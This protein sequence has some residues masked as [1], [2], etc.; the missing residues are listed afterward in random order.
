MNIAA[1]CS[2]G[3]GYLADHPVDRDF[4]SEG[5]EAHAHIAARI[6]GLPPPDCSDPGVPW[7]WLEEL[8]EE[9]GLC[10]EDGSVECATPPLE[11]GG[12]LTTG[13]TDWH[14]SDGRRLVVVDWK[15]GEGQRW[16]LPPMV[17]WYQGLLY[18]VQ[19]WKNEEEVLL[20]RPRLCDREVDELRLT[21]AL[22]EEVIYPGLEEIVLGVAD[23]PDTLHAGPWC[24]G[25]LC[26]ETCPARAEQVAPWLALPVALPGPLELAQALRWAQARGAVQAACEAA[27]AALRA[28][29]REGGVIEADGYRLCLVATSRESVSDVERVREVVGPE[30]VEVKV[31][32]S[33]TL[34][35]R[36]LKKRKYKPDE[37]AEVL[38]QLRAAGAIVEKETA[39]RLTWKQ[40]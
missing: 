23:A 14:H 16:I 17:R 6:S 15:W 25:C 35:E 32:S 33:K 9:Y 29:L 39:G 28:F 10:W 27:D 3:P 12:Y 31:T 22:I 24:E 38:N 20:L 11:I 37:R 7:D 2:G 34:I 18:V 36:V 4:L 21:P 1:D 13:H 26:R 19:L 8:A 30:A 5:Q 40:K